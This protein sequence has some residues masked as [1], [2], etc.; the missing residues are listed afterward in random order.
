MSEGTSI[1]L[2]TKDRPET[3]KE[4][5]TALL[6]YAAKPYEIIIV[7]NGSE[8]NT[9]LSL[10]AQAEQT[11]ATVVRNKA[12]LGLSRAT[13]QGLALGTKDTLLH[14]DD[15]CLLKEHGWNQRMRGYLVAHEKIGLVVPS[16]TPEFI[17]HP[18][19]RE[20][21]WGLGMCWAMRKS[22]FD[23]IGGY[24]PQLLHQNEC[25][26]ALRVRM[27]GYHVAGIQD[28][29]P[30]H[31]DPGGER[32]ELSKAREHLGCV[33]YRDKWC[34][35]FRGREWNY[36]SIPLYL[37]E[38]WPPDQEWLRQFAYAN[39]IDLNPPPPEHKAEDTLP[40]MTIG[41]T[42]ESAEKIERRFQINGLWYMAYVDVRNTYGHWVR[43]D[44][45]DRDRDKAIA[46]WKELTGEEYTGYKWPNLLRVE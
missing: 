16:T 8:S 20:I 11:G 40:G 23:D 19:Y 46:R 3:F 25:D 29:K 31:N 33:Q 17:Q 37:M 42:P 36:G 4:T 35:Y 18:G 32:S 22:L 39:K 28:V 13:N 12:N 30:I 24:D 10:L 2:V 44:H 34:Q 45:Y 38:A 14:L 6:T 26:L 9:M 43:G 41:I 21:R 5:F 1:C 15:D 27:A 7:D